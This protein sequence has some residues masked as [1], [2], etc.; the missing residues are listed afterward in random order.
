MSRRTR[1]ALSDSER[2]E[3]RR[4][5][6]ELARQAVERLRSSDSWQRWLASR[7]HFHSYSLA[8]QLL[9]ATRHARGNPGRGAQ[10]WLKL[11][12]C[13]RKGERA[14]IRIWCPR[15]P[16]KQRLQAWRDAGADPA[17]RPRTRFALGPV[18]D[19]SQVSE[20]P[21]PAEPIPLDPPIHEVSG[22][23]SRGRSSR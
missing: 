21:P 6:R 10:A 1:S 15:P 14:V 9:I 16:S 13:V 19:R 11:G 22:D 5:D 7:R 4:A 2:A 3:L 23:G 20:L 12:Y 8:N 17:E 18:W